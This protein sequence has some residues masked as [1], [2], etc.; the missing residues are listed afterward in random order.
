[1]AHRPGVLAVE[2]INGTQMA[3]Y[4][5]KE[6]ITETFSPWLLLETPEDASRAGLEGVSNMVALKGGGEL[7]HRVHFH[8]WNHFLEARDRLSSDGI[9]HFN[10][11]TPVRQHLMLTGQ[12]LFKEMRF[13]DLHRLQLDIETLSLDPQA[14]NAEIIIISISDTQGFETVLSGLDLS[15]PERLQQLCIIIADRDPDIIEGHNIFEF[16]LPYIAARAQAHNIPL[17]WGRDGSNLRAGHGRQR[18]K[19]GAQRPDFRPSYIH[20]RHIIDTYHQVQRYDI[21]GNLESYG[22]KPVVRAL[23]LERE[24]RTFVAGE[25]IAQ[26]WRTDPQKLIAYALDDVRDVR[27]LSKL[28]V[29]T[30]F[31]QTQVLPYSFQAAALSGPGEKINAMMVGH[32]L[33]RGLAIPRPRKNKDLGGGYTK[34][35]SDGIFQRVVKADVE[36]LYPSIMLS[37][38]I[39][40]ATDTEDSF[41]PMLEHLTH[42]RLEAKTS[43][44]NATTETDRTYWNGVQGSY[45][46]LINSF[47]GYLA[48]GRANFNDYDAAGRVT[49]IGQQIAHSMVNTLKDFGAEI[50]EV[51]TDGVYFV[52]PPNVKTEDDENKLIESI[53]AT[54]PKGIHLSHDGRFKGMISLKAKNYILSDYENTLTVKGSSLRSRRD[55]LIFRRFITD[56]A[57]LLIE[58]N[59]QKAS[60][61]YLDLA[62][63]LQDGKVP[64]DDFCRWERISKKTFSNPNLRRLAQAA[65]DSNIGDKIAVYQRED[66]SLARTEFFAHDEDRK[67]LLRRLHDTAERFHTL[68]TDAEFKKLFPQVQPKTRNQLTLF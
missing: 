53:S 27:D 44:Q 47:Y 40:P 39:R 54:L 31:Y 42:R 52:A 2:L 36:S 60:Q 66:G 10:I 28:V 64:P 45:K 23:G 26:T 6:K 9:M 24:D 59:F 34:L 3:V 65:E 15:E 13:D 22:L 49:T 16:D 41:L 4:T 62:Y 14:P 56:L 25:D 18:Y 20:G 7:R 57:P 63:Q 68:F 37:N 29:P 30:E 55:E 32:Y 35:V 21:G 5:R 19:V 43:F 38:Q 46:I 17:T 51:D 33:R 11:N 58:Q 67:Y 61:T 48:Y 50:I 12:T 8:T 1:M